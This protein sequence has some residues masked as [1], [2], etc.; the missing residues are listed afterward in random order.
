MEI[1]IEYVDSLPGG[2][3]V[4]PVERDGAFGWL[5]VEGH[6]SRQA[7]AEMV[8]DLGHII[9]TGLWRQNWQPPT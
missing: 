9:H 5:V 6:V 1:S 3:V 8:A 4:M 7:G 2:R